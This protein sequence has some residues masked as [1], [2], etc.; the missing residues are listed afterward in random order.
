MTDPPTWIKPATGPRYW[1]SNP[2]PELDRLITLF[3][4]ALFR[5]DETYGPEF[6]FTSSPRHLFADDDLLLATAADQMAFT[7][8]D[9]AD[10]IL[11]LAATIREQ[12]AT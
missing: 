12:A 5:E 10:E 3:H 7:V 8:L 11:A 1:G 6:R 2:S 9:H 4:H